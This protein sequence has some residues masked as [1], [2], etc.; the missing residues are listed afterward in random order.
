MVLRGVCKHKRP[1]ARVATRPLSAK[2]ASIASSSLWSD[3]RRRCVTYRGRAPF[4]R[5]PSEKSSL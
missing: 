4:P 3:R 5:R 1:F 2:R